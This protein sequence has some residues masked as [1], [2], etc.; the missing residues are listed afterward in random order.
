MKPLIVTITAGIIMTIGLSAGETSANPAVAGLNHLAGAFIE[1]TLL[2]RTHGGHGTRCAYGTYFAVGAA[3]QRTGFHQHVDEG[4]LGAGLPANRCKG[5]LEQ[6]Q[7][8]SSPDLS[9]PVTRCTG[10]KVPYNNRCV[11]PKGTVEYQGKCTTLRQ[12]GKTINP[13]LISPR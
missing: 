12:P 2:H 5:P 7:P 13:N 10:G 11:C 4:P 6:V 3:G 1:N 9:G 8:D